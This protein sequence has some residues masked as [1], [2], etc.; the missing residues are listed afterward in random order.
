MNP[1]RLYRFD[2]FCL[3]ATAKVLL[4]DGQPVTIT[5]KAVETLLVLTE[6]AG[7]VVSK[8]ELLKAI[9]PDRV[10]EEA[11]L[12]QNIA[13]VR[14]ALAAER[15]TAAYIE[16]FPGRGYRLVGP[17]ELDETQPA[18]GNGHSFAKSMFVAESVAGPVAGEALLPAT[19]LEQPANGTPALAAAPVNLLAT[20]KRNRALVL[21]GIWLLLPFALFLLAWYFWPRQPREAAAVF[22]VTSLT[23]LPGK[24]SQPALSP[25][26]KQVAF[27]WEQEDGQTPELLVQ[28]DG[29]S[30]ALPIAK[31]AGHYSSPV[32]S[33]DGQ[34]LAYLRI[35]KAATEVL[36]T[37][38]RSAAEVATV[39]LVTQFT[40]PNY[41]SP[42]RL[43]DWSPDGQWL[44][45][46]HA[47]STDKPNGLFLVNLATGERK[48]LTNPTEMVG[49]DLDPRF[50]PDGQAITFIRHMQRAHQE[51]YLI[52]VT[53][54]EARPLTAANK[55]ISSH[56]WLGDGSGL[57]FASDRSGEFRLWRLHIKA[58]TANTDPERIEI[59]GAFPIELSL[60][61]KAPRLAYSVQQQ[62][63]NIWRLDLQEKSWQRLLA[64]S[65][66]D[67]SP[68]Y[69]PDGQRICF[70]SDRNGEE[71]LW[72]SDADGNNA[73]QI[74]QSAVYPSVGHWSPDGRQ[75][76][77]HNSKSGELY[78][79][80][81]LTPGR[82]ETHPLGINGVHPVFAPDGA[83]LYA[84]TTKQIFKL[85][86]TGGTPIEVVKTGGFSLGL[87]QDGKLLYFMRDVNDTVLWQ[88]RTDT[89]ELARAV[90]GILPACT[91]CWA[92]TPAGIY[93][94]GSDKTSF[95]AQAIYFHRFNAPPG[96]ADRLII[97]YPEPLAPVGS[98]PF[99]LAPDLRHLLVVRMNPSNSDIMRVEPFR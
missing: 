20:P 87:A 50:A 72:V 40:P 49:G 62:D 14:R 61:R 97:K 32:W 19:A 94:L 57:V 46:S 99:S 80:R 78:L 45:V 64:S 48:R 91:S 2:A 24:E 93:Y 66:Q 22:R 26:G 92:L 75:I 37:N 55:Q 77:F 88:A 83:W 35:G 28:T 53:G 60:A 98:G 13:M 65:A 89:G 58:G 31:A 39:R 29:I 67:A 27:L 17:V 38:L 76:A 9:W 90:D 12:T 74:T 68:Q 15:G 36:V 4:R 11:N 51:L 69:A 5:R 42:F 52:P 71:H 23:S 81:E 79:T 10:V 25:D 43:L 56:A 8:E 3:D 73:M 84:G 1:H 7:Q 82:W 6:N 33:P 59:F 54:G 34:A 85:P 86:V 18:A 30:T 21:R 44:V 63:R 41:G 95:D 47:A 96:E 70:R 16:T